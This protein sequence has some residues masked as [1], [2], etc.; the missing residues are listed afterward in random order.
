[1]ATISVQRAVSHTPSDALFSLLFPSALVS[2]THLLPP[3]PH[4]QPPT[5][6]LNPS[7]LYAFSCIL[8]HFHPTLTLTLTNITLPNITL[9]N[10]TLSRSSSPSPTSPSLALAH[11]PQHHPLLLSL[12]L[13]LS[14]LAVT[15]SQIHSLYNVPIFTS[16]CSL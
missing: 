4:T 16:V 7:L 13:T 5:P 15:T 11:P 3:S 10:I 1:M 9:P 12:S 6:D 2:S 14:S 8:S